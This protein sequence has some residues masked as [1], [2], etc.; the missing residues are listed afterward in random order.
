M[1]WED[2]VRGSYLSKSESHY[3]G[4]ARRPRVLAS[5]EKRDPGPQQPDLSIVS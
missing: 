2:T 3:G 1:E 5:K 4:Q